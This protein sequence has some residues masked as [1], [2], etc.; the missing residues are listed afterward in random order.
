M[1]KIIGST[2]HDRNRKFHEMERCSPK[3]W[4]IEAFG[5]QYKCWNS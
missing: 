1:Y 3:Y 2:V 4:S 5:G